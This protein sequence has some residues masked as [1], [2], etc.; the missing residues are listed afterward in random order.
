M[1]KG[2]RGS[3]ALPPCKLPNTMYRI[4]TRVYDDDG[5]VDCDDLGTENNWDATIHNE[6][7]GG[8]A[9]SATRTENK[10]Y[11]RSL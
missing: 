3:G 1:E 2:G 4:G 8:V 10:L 6:N 7:G 5:D 11:R 9:M